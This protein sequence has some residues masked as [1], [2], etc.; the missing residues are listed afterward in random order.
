MDL[1]GQC[2]EGAIELGKFIEKSEGNGVATI[3]LLED[4]CE[5]TYQIYEKLA[6][7][8]KLNANKRYKN[9]RKILIQIE[10]SVKND[11]KIRFEII[12]LPYKASMWD[13]MESV[14][15]AADRDPDCDAYVVPIPYY[16]R[17]PMVH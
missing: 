1:L 15:K 6:G 9:L 5:Q 4:Y 7:G 13:S 3:A 2:Q 12:F 8:Q 10:N 17:E 11:I 14:W 16:D